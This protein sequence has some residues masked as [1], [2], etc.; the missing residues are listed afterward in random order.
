MLDTQSGN[1]LCDCVKSLTS[2][3]TLSQLLH[4]QVPP[5]D[6]HQI[7]S[8]GV[9]VYHVELRAFALCF[10]YFPPAVHGVL[11]PNIQVCPSG[12]PLGCSSEST[13]E[14]VI[15]FH[16]IACSNQLRFLLLDLLHEVVK[17]IIV[18]CHQCNGAIPVAKHRTCPTPLLHPY[19]H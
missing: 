15:C 7:P 13:Q 5:R 4:K 9:V 18:L 14:A 12:S 6:R 2:L 10:L 1:C 8:V 11:N 16:V 3:A 19:S 17:Y